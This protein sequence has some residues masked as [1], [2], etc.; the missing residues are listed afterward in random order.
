MK[1][2]D[3]PKWIVLSPDG[4]PIEQNEAI[5]HTIAPKSYD[6][7]GEACYRLGRWV[8][9]FKENGY[10]SASGRHFPVEEIVHHCRLYYSQEALALEPP[11]KKQNKKGETANG[12]N[13][14]SNTRK[15]PKPKS[16]V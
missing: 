1:D 4:V 15:L 11:Q 6:S 5:T 10:Y 13:A 14:G 16:S 9:K 8:S 2:Y 7:Y 12:N 3:K